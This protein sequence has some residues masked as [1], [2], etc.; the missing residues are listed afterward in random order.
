MKE[1]KNKNGQF[2]V[3]S[4]GVKLSHSSLLKPFSGTFL[5]A[6]RLRTRRPAD[7]GPFDP[8]SEAPCSQCCR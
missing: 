3:M 8:C 4:Y 1:K 6:Q 2:E 7:V 5:V